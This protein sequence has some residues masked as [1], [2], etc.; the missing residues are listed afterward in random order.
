M[1]C[2]RIGVAG[3]TLLL[4]YAAVGTLSWLSYRPGPGFPV[5]HAIA[6]AEIGLVLA[7]FVPGLRTVSA[8]IIQW[9]FLGAGVASAIVLARADLTPS[10]HCLGAEPIPL[11]RAMILQGIAVF[12]AALVRVGARPPVSA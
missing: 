1:W 6:F 4:G 2:A 7:L 9:A 3:L 5:Y 12:L 8:G 10:C 11:S